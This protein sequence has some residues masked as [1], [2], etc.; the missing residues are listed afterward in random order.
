MKQTAPRSFSETENRFKGIHFFV[1]CSGRVHS[2]SDVC[3]GSI[4]FQHFNLLPLL[5]DL[6]I[7]E[8]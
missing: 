6:W 1:G 5:L 2:K 3:I 7:R 8:K 4:G